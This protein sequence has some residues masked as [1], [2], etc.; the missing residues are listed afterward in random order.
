MKCLLI[1]IGFEYGTI[2]LEFRHC[3]S[4][5]EEKQGEPTTMT[6]TTITIQN[7]T[8]DITTT[9]TQFLFD[10]NDTYSLFTFTIYVFFILCVTLLPT[11]TTMEVSA[12]VTT[13]TNR[14]GYNG[15][16]KCGLF[17]NFIFDKFL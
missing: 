14:L 10:S 6:S 12:S 16:D 5:Q 7:D 11:T 13:H 1:T 17:N 9:A 4:K 2:L 15:C 8:N 3:F